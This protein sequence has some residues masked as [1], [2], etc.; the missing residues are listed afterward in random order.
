L[1]SFAISK[2]NQNTD[3]AIALAEDFKTSDGKQ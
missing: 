2:C 1:Q 3:P